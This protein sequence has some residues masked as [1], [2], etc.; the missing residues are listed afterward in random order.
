MEPV[1]VTTRSQLRSVLS[2][3]LDDLRPGWLTTKEARRRLS[4]SDKTLSRYRTEGI[5]RFSKS[6]GLVYYVESDIDS[7]LAGNPTIHPTAELTKV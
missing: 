2:E 5:L 1:I 7:L 4:V 6:R 3:V